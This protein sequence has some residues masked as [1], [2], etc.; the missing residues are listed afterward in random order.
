MILDFEV[1]VFDCDG[2][3]LDS[4]KIKGNVFKIVLDEFPARKVKKFLKFHYDNGGV[5]R[6]LKFKYFFE[7]I[8]IVDDPDTF[9]K[10][11]SNKF[12]SMVKSQLLKS[13]LVP[14][15][16]NFL[17]I[18]K[19][20]KKLCFVNSGSEQNEL[21]E[22]LTKKEISK[23]FDF[24]L[25]S[26]KSKVENN[27]IIEN[28]SKGQKKKIFFGDSKNDYV[29]AKKSGMDFVFLSQFSEWKNPHGKFYKTINNFE[30]LI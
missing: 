7:E 11:Y 14:G 21:I 28:L 6:F 12:S 30:E 27:E 24:I 17:R 26:P 15:V 5:S 9:V 19:L 25:G 29:A 2:V 20:N 4:N 16:E 3:I 23:Y 13:T 8:H 18:L 1:Y 22:I 10:D